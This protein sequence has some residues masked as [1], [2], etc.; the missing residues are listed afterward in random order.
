MIRID[1]HCIATTSGTLFARRW[2]PEFAGRDDPTILL[3]HD[4]LGSVELWR[5]FPE[6]LASATGLPV[7]A[8]DRLGFGRSDPNPCRLGR[9]FIMDEARVSVAALRTQLRID[10]LIPFGHSVGGAMAIATAAAYPEASAAVITESA[11]AFVEDRT[12]AGI[13]DAQAQFADPGQ[14]ARL[15][16]YHGD[17]AQW[18]LDAWIKTWLGPD[19]ADWTL[20][21]LLAQVRCPVLA[22]HGDHDEFG[23]DAHPARIAAMAGGP[24]STVFFEDCGHVPHR[25]Q[26]ERVLQDV[27]GFFASSG[28]LKEAAGAEG[29]SDPAVACGAHI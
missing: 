2:R 25:E 12:L 23:S 24:S 6:A 26:P 28:L 3:F 21:G 17:K 22:M 15:A 5:G 19:F 16:R 11:Q 7:M 4:S 27:T 20:D 18:V 14:M 10:R 9:D 13:R 29:P 8:Y 1:D